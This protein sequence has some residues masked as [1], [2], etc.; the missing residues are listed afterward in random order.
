[1]HHHNKI[2]IRKRVKKQPLALSALLWNL[3]T[4]ASKNISEGD[5]KYECEK[6]SLLERKR[7]SKGVL[8]VEASPIYRGVNCL[9][10]KLCLLKN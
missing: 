7:V 5:Q 9:E 2:S 1:M 10:N 8:N 4:L 6:V 3:K